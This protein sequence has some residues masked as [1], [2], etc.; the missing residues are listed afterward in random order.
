MNIRV[1]YEDTDCGGVVYYANY[2]RFMERS[3]T[4]FLRELGIDQVSYQ[5][6]GI[7]FV[8]I[9]AHV[10]YRSPARYDDLLSIESSVI[11]LSSA[12]VVFETRILRDNNLLVKGEVKLACIGPKGHV[13]KIPQEIREALSTTMRR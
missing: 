2:L 9:E 11:E 12:T 10:K 4:E 8:V 3:R 6:K 7:F 5:K 13:M 1:Y